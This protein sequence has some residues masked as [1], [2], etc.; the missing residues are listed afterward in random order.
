[1]TRIPGCEVA[2]MAVGT[3][4]ECYRSNYDSMGRGLRKG[5][6]QEA[7][8]FSV[9]IC[10]LP[11]SRAS[12]RDGLQ[13]NISDNVEQKCI[14]IRIHDIT[15]PRAYFRTSEIRSDV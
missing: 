9:R 1:M 8:I 10:L 4:A 2:V 14:I 13:K 6:H 3:L 15:H 12:G 7:P 11:A 5:Y